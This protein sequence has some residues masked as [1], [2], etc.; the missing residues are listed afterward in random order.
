MSTT[1]VGDLLDLADHQVRA[2]RCS[3]KPI[4]LGAWATFETTAKRLLGELVGPPPTLGD[5][6]IQTH[7]V[8]Q[9]IFDRFPPP[10]D[11]RGSPKI[12]NILDSTRPASLASTEPLDQLSLTLGMLADMIAGARQ[13]NLFT[14]AGSDLD[15]I[16]QEAEATPVIMHLLAMISATGLY[17]V[18]E[19]SAD[20]TKRP[21]M[22][23]RYAE[24]A[25]DSLDGWGRGSRLRDLASFAPTNAPAT[26]N[27]RLEQALGTWVT[28]ATDELAQT[29]PSTEV[30]RNITNQAAH[31]YAATDHLLDLTSATGPAAEQ[32]KAPAAARA[33]LRRA[34]GAMRDVEPLWGTV[35]TAFRPSHE[36]VS[37]ATALFESLNEL[38]ATP[39]LEKAPLEKR[40]EPLQDALDV[41]RALTD[42]RQAGADLRDLL[43][44]S[45][46]LP[47]ILIRSQLLYA[48]ARVLSGRASRLRA[49]Q[50]GRWIAITPA[51]GSHLSRAANE[52]GQAATAAQTALTEQLRGAGV[53]CALDRQHGLSSAVSHD[54]GLATDGQ[55]LASG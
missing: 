38:L 6:R 31:M 41:Q 42:L 54:R 24:R 5:D 29:I 43:H 49:R 27:E 12:L 30:L 37:A 4:T 22:V 19:L 7:A 55:R 10:P 52:A 28:A 3:S 23:T 44:T 50:L 40:N 18:S 17:T 25:L 21:L 16:L 13:R 46:E 11:R 34:A 26:T 36:Y 48:P 39:P 51:D 32:V 20:Q 53:E 9:Q 15:T 14:W 1:T 47:D 35:T 33:E 8:H 2:L 45:A